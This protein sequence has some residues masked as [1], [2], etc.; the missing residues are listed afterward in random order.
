MRYL[1]IITLF[2]CKYSFCQDS[3]YLYFK[4][5][6]IPI[7]VVEG[8]SWHDS[9][10]SC[11]LFK[12]S[13]SNYL[14]ASFSTIDSSEIESGMLKLIR[15]DTANYLIRDGNWISGNNI[16]KFSYE[17][18]SFAGEENIPST[19]EPKIFIKS[20]KHRKNRRSQLV[21]RPK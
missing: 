16:K 3:A 8:F 10:F 18:F 15:I 20:K 17:F 1:F 4:K 2:F 13:N 9:A 6:Y 12:I 19:N 7:P 14:F 21:Q 5:R 11:K